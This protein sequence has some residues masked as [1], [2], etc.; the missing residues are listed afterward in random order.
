MVIGENTWR[1]ESSEL[2]WL[3]HREGHTASCCV[4]RLDVAWEGPVGQGRQ[5]GSWQKPRPESSAERG[6]QTRLG[7]LMWDPEYLGVEDR[8][9]REGS[10]GLILLYPGEGCASLQVLTKYIILVSLLNLCVLS[11]V[12]LT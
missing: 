5:G 3:H 2:T 11:V 7:H 9:Q 6:G 10:G 4:G 8:E 12:S 1:V